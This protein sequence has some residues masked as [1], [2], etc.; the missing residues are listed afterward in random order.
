MCCIG[1]FYVPTFNSF[2]FAIVGAVFTSMM[3]GM[4]LH[5]QSRDAA[6]HMHA[7]THTLTYIYIHTHTRERERE[8][9]RREESRCTRTRV[10]FSCLDIC[11]SIDGNA[12]ACFPL[13]LC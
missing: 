10:F 4:A 11:W 1:M 13:L 8:R 12:C 7:C 3:Q 6:R 9:E 5:R 2:I